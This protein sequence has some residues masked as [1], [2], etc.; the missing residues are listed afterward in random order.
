MPV[1]LIS[2][3]LGRSPYADLLNL[4]YDGV[5]LS[6]ADHRRLGMCQSSQHRAQYARYRSHYHYEAAFVFD[7]AAICQEHSI[8]LVLPSHKVTEIRARS[9]NGLHR[10]STR[11]FPLLGTLRSSMRRS[12]DM[13]SRDPT[14][15]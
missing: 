15:T 11:C 10:S 8:G 12:G 5:R 3:V 4:T 9:A 6:V 2:D 13:T 14:P 1:L 7:S